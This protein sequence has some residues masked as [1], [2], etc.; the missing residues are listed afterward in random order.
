MPKL[1]RTLGALFR[2]TL[3]PAERMLR[4]SMDGA[5]ALAARD[6]EDDASHAP[7]FYH[8]EAH[9]GVAAG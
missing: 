4:P 8:D 2:L 1:Q 9:G 6:A 5:A 7:A 3:E